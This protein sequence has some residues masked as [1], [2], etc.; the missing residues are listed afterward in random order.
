MKKKQSNG[1]LA[2]NKK[3]ITELSHPQHVAGG[4]YLDTRVSCI[5]RCLCPV[6]GTCPR[7]SFEQRC[8]PCPINTM[9]CPTLP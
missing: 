9:T 5:S 6:S 2:L 8:P 3:W 1:R 7:P 4:E